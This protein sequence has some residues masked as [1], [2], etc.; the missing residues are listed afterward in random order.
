MDA[1]TTLENAVGGFVPLFEP[2]SIYEACMIP[3]A[4]LWCALRRAREKKRSIGSTIRQKRLIRAMERDF[5]DQVRAIP[6][7]TVYETDQR[8]DR[9]KV[10]L[11]DGFI[12]DELVGV[13]YG[14]PQRPRDHL[15]LVVDLISFDEFIQANQAEKAGNDEHFREWE[16]MASMFA[17]A[18]NVP[19]AMLALLS[20]RTGDLI[21]R[22]VERDD[23]KTQTRILD[24]L[25]MMEI[26]NE[27]PGVISAL[28]PNPIN[29]TCRTCYH[30][31]P[32]E[33]GRWSCGKFG[34]L[35][36]QTQS[37]ANPCHIVHP[38]F[39]P[40]E[41]IDSPTMGASWY[42]GPGGEM[43]EIL[44]L[45]EMEKGGASLC[46]ITLISSEACA[47]RA[48]GEMLIDQ[49]VKNFKENFAAKASN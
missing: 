2:V 46:D 49:N 24:I 16:T 22:F 8:G 43:L 25:H 34:I 48:S 28:G 19:G 1:K 17:Q 15:A 35:T 42:K 31:N 7:V 21:I 3:D 9:F 36:D 18:A 5:V 23:D 14:L 27:P 26:G 38:E 45:E 29:V 20:P 13:A 44:S 47:L 32:N 12:E 10:S 11:L 6:G 33:G 30:C 40:L 39:I 41:I 4:S 37:R